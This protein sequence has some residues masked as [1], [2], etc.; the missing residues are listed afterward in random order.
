MA[1]VDLGHVQHPVGAPGAHEEQPPERVQQFGVAA[2]QILHLGPLLLH[3]VAP[4]ALVVLHLK[5]RRRRGLHK[6]WPSLYRFHWVFR[7]SIQL[8]GL[9]MGIH[10]L[11]WIVKGFVCFIIEF[12]WVLL[13]FTWFDTT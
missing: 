3:P 2:G 1:D 9:E 12:D 13:C 7:G 11:Y 5:R 8:G 4:L 10:G 6:G